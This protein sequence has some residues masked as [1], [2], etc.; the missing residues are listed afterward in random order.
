MTNYEA[1][2][3]AELADDEYFST[4]V[5]H[6]DAASD[7]FWQAWMAEHPEKRKS[8]AEARQL[9]LF[10]RLK[11]RV[12]DP[13]D[14]LEVKRLIDARINSGVAE[15]GLAGVSR[16][17]P[18]V[19]WQS[20]RK[21]AAAVGLLITL[22]GLLWYYLN[23]PQTYATA[24]GETRT[25]VLPDRSR[26]TLNGNSRISFPKSWD[27]EKPREISLSGE[28]FFSVVHTASH[29]QFIV[30]TDD[31]LRVEVLG[32]EFNVANRTGRTRVVLNSGKVKLHFPP[33]DS[34][35]A[36]VMKPG[37]MV[38]F[39]ENTHQVR[40]EAVEAGNFSAWTD[41]KIILDNTP[42]AEIALLLQDVYGLQVQIADSSLL[43]KKLWG[44]MPTENVDDFLTVLSKSFHLKITRKGQQVLIQNQP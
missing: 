32:T 34:A 7:A 25:V 6:P 17:A 10:L 36:I 24:F 12:P 41:H 19:A 31:Q 40:K 14:A 9:V 1:Y 38:E 16:P 44:S 15:A 11:V 18:G 30:R 21:M 43:Q 2:T 8:V 39:Q 28:A 3:S 37:E 23:A 20:Y 13:A 4:W 22:G 29:Q 26:V 27:P 5:R 42:V 35:A 33:V